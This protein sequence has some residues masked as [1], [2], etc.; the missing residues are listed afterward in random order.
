MQETSP[1][2]HPLLRRPLVGG[3]LTGNPSLD[4]DP[5]F[6]WR[7]THDVRLYYLILWLDRL[8]VLISDYVKPA[9]AIC[10]NN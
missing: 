8:Y 3:K 4:A 6:G 9:R 10:R 5:G 7:S 1:W 2:I